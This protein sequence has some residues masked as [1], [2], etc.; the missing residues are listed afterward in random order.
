MWMG[1]V[2]PTLPPHG[3]YNVKS[4]RLW[5]AMVSRRKWVKKLNGVLIKKC[6]LV[7]Q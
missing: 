6:L 5:R 4:W 2:L 1:Q 3:K 7:R